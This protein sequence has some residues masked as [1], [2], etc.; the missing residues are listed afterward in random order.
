[1]SNTKYQINVELTCAHN[2]SY[3][4]AR[5]FD[6][7]D[8][9][10]RTEWIIRVVVPV[11]GKL[12]PSKSSTLAQRVSEGSRIPVHMDV[13]VSEMI[14]IGLWLHRKHSNWPQ[15]PGNLPPTAGQGEQNPGWSPPLQGLGEHDSWGQRGA[16]STAS[17]SRGGALGTLAQPPDSP[18]APGNP[19]HQL[20][21]GVARTWDHY[22][23][24]KQRGK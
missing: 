17:L 1:M 2:V 5:W 18:P 7:I 23:F 19:W 20:T 8:F 9:S 11:I 15:S 14:R 6:T 3:H 10:S 12:I 21:P 4:T 24:R 13:Y 22:S 16:H